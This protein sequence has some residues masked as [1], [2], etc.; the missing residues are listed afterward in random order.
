M[1][2]AHPVPKDFRLREGVSRQLRLINHFV[3]IHSRQKA[4]RSRHVLIKLCGIRVRMGMD[5]EK[6]T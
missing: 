5:Y 1:L 3:P 6:V 2:S 4:I